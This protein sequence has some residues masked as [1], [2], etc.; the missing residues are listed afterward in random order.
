MSENTPPS[1]PP[2]DGVPQNPM[3]ESIRGYRK[4]NKATSDYINRV[5]NLGD[6][7]DALINDATAAPGV[8]ADPRMVALAR[9]KFQEAAM[10]LI[11]AAAR[12]DGLF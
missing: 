2:E 7:V 1:S 11:R 5:K 10:W 9:T 3:A 12:P 6:D 8:D 4:F